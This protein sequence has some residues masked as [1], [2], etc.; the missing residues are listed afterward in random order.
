MNWFKKKPDTNLPV[1][2]ATKYSLQ[3]LLD[4]GS[5]PSEDTVSRWI[6]KLKTLPDSQLAA[7]ESDMDAVKRFLR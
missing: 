1:A 7:L 4:R 6:T 2:I 3:Y 5:M